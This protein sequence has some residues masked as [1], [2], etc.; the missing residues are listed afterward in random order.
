MNSSSHKTRTIHVAPFFIFVFAA[1]LTLSTTV[2]AES[3]A[4]TSPFSTGVARF[5]LALGG[6]T[7]FNRNYAIL[8]LG[9]GY[10]IFDSIELGLDVE[11]WSGNSPRIELVSPQLRV[12]LSGY[13]SVRPYVGVFHRHAFIDGYADQDS[14]GARAGAFL[15]SGRNAYF[16]VGLAQEAHINCDRNAY[17]AC[18][19]TYPE[20]LFAVMF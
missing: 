16:G 5:S 13:G 6:A 18:A 19:E 17:A 4:S 12:V 3:G 11:E 8:G 15:L 1:L 14:L 7:A 10:F 9:A 20:L 2:H